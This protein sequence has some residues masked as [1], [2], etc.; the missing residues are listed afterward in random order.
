MWAFSVIYVSTDFSLRKLFW[1]QLI[2]ISDA[3]NSIGGLNWMVRE[4]LIEILRVYEKFGG[5][6]LN[7]HRSSLFWDCLNKCGL[8]DLGYKSSKYTW[9]NMRYKNR[10]SLILERLDRCLANDLWLHFFPEAS[11][12]NLPR[13]HSDHSP[14][15]IQLQQH[16]CTPC[17]TFR[18]E[19]I[20]CSHRDFKTL[21]NNSFSEESNLTR[22]TLD[23]EP[24][25]KAWN[26]EVFCNIF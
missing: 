9:S 22:A 4:D 3:L 12:L 20:W 21:V 5:N 18:V 10:G 16:L 13:T 26:K 19:S 23:F 17:K 1:E 7:I 14:L 24:I 15:L 8:M 11:I 6:I 25:A 2:C